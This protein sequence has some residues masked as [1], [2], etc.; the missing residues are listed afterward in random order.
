MRVFE[1]SEGD[2]WIYDRERGEVARSRIDAARLQRIAAELG[3]TYV[4]S[5]RPGQVATAVAGRLLGINPFDQP[6]VESAKQAAR[7]LLGGGS[8]AADEPA[9]VD[10]DIQVRAAGG[11]WLDHA[12]AARLLADRHWWPLFAEGF[13]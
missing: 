8:G 7:D 10:G 9:F 2:D 6:D 11:D 1:G 13:E 12:T 3:V 4:H 5:E